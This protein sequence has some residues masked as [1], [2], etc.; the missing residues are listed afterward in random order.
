M[1]DTKMT[2]SNERSI[3]MKDVHHK[4]LSTILLTALFFVFANIATAQEGYEEWKENYLQEFKEFQNK[5]DRQFHKMLQN[6]WKEFDVELSPDFYEK[7]K[8][9]V[10]PKA[11]KENEENKNTNNTVNLNGHE[12]ESTPKEENNQ[13]VK[14][15]DKTRTDESSKKT[16]T[17]GDNKTRSQGKADRPIAET[18]LTPSF[19]PS[20]K[21]AEIKTNE[22]SY[23]DIPIRYKFY[24]A[25]KKRMDRPV[26]KKTI[27]NFWKHLST[28]DYPSFLE[29]IQEVRSRL[30]LNDYGYAQLLQ[31]IGT[32]IYGDKTPESTLFTW[33]MLT[34][35]G[36]G[37]RIAYNDDNVY[38]LTKTTPG[39]FRT[40][41][42]MID[43]EKY[44][45]INFTESSSKL[46]SNLF[47]Y[48]GD[49]PKSDKKELNLRFSRL[50][51]LPEIRETRE[52]SFS[53][54]DTSYSF[55]V[56]VDQQLINYFKDYPKAQLGLYFNSRMRGEMHQELMSSLRP[57]IQGKSNVEKANILLRFV[58]NAFEY[59]TDQKQ[60]N[61]EKKM[62]PAEALYYPA[63]DCDDRSILFA[64]LIEH[65]TDMEYIVLRYPGHL[66]TALH[67]PSDPPSG[68]KVGRPIQHDGKNYYVSDPTYFGADAGMVMSQFEGT[69]PSEIFDL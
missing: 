25:Y 4:L 31:N 34:Q 28:K 20:V 48:E 18:G 35:S 22:L 66:T 29:Q 37:T 57:L 24:A 3:I 6:E 10:I 23:F 62:F 45:G 15:A 54:H 46:P 13:P 56:P 19:N 36:F 9:E 14:K 16:E 21:Q 44:Y 11:E 1:S 63:N 67:F 50:P 51:M 8:P 60:F 39:V 27:S 65:L 52:L 2:S 61:T 32:Q 17:V 47:T 41:Y 42:F 69:Q 40:T 58:Q 49:Y 26:V 38:L 53:Y 55:T 12:K 68:P 59:K 5:Y 43:G 64:Y 7:P 33:F 30:S